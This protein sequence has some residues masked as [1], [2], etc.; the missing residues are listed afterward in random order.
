MG[1]G[2]GRQKAFVGLSMDVGLLFAGLFT[3]LPHCLPCQPLGLLILKS[4]FLT[5]V[6]RALLPCF[7]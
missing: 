4:L 6:H 1:V 7:C 2:L 3:C 5:K